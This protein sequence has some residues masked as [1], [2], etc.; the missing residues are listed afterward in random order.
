MAAF[1]DDV[2]LVPTHALKRALFDKYGP[3]DKRIKRIENATLFRVDGC[4]IFKGANGDPLSHVCM[5]FVEVEDNANLTVR[6][7]GNVPLEG[8]VQDWIGDFGTKLGASAAQ[9]PG[10]SFKLKKGE[11]N[12]LAKLAQAMNSVVVGRSYSRPSFKYTCPRVAGAL[13]ELKGVIDGVWH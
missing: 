6:F 12:N 7:H 4:E 5:I 10:L 9:A 3:S 1:F 2:E 13:R 11:Q 8:P